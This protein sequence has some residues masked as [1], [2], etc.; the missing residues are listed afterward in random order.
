M[1]DNKFIDFLNSEYNNAKESLER[2]EALDR[3][4]DEL[5]SCEKRYSDDNELDQGGMKVISRVYDKITDRT[6]VKAKSKFPEDKDHT[7]LFLRE[8]RITASLQHPNIVPIHDIGFDDDNS[9]YFIMKM[10]DGKSFQDYLEFENNL[11]TK[12]SAFLKIC[13]G[14]DFAHSEGVVHLDLKPANI[15][16]GEHGE[17]IIFDWGLA[18]V[19]YEDCKEE[20]LKK[21]SLDF[22]NLQLTLYGRGTPGYMAPE[23]F[24]NGAPLTRQSDIFSL[25]AILYFILT[26]KAPY[27]G[28]NYEEIKKKTLQGNLRPP[29]LAKPDLDIPLGLEAICMKALQNEPSERYQTVEEMIKEVSAYMNGFAPKAENASFSTQLKLLYLRNKAIINVVLSAILIIIIGLFWFISKIKE[30]ENIN[31]L[32]KERLEAEAQR[33]QSAETTAL[34]GTVSIAWKNLQNAD[35]R[36]AMTQAS[37]A[38]QYAPSYIEPYRIATLTNLAKFNFEEALNYSNELPAEKYPQLRA[39]CL[40]LSD[41]QNTHKDYLEIIKLFKINSREKIYPYLIASSL[42]KIKAED[43]ADFI[44]KLIML[45][46]ENLALKDIILSEDKKLLKINSQNLIEFPPLVEDKINIVD[47]SGSK[48]KSLES[49]SQLKVVE[50]NISGCEINDYSFLSKF[51]ELKKLTVS[52]GQVPEK[53]LFTLP[54]KIVEL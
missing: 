30:S 5:Q 18:K 24:K 2:H 40:K 43:K 13:D 12:L 6:L 20:L 25:G 42:D 52:K 35:L 31:R 3:I 37:I 54:F 7:E 9:P 49:F 19:I 27:E 39:I 23:Q 53:I 46:N 15:K 38:I 32:A 47:V 41:Q 29:S 10:I 50:L 28:E 33:R 36:G 44:K 26:G 21:D 14:I 16:V 8:A 48:L 51:S 45:H 22:C 1:K 11:T 17:V 34:R 4:S